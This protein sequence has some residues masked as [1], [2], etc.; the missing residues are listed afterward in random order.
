VGKDATA[1]GR[2][3][4]GRFVEGPSEAA[5]ALGRST[6][7]DVRLWRDD[8]AG[9]RAHLDEL[10]R[11]GLI[12]DDQRARIAKALDAIEAEFSAGEF[13]FADTDEDLHGAIE[14]RLIERAGEDGGRLRAGRSRNDQIATDLRRYLRRTIATELIP[15]VAALQ[16]A[17]VDQAEQAIDMVAPGYTHL[18]RAQPVTVAHH[19]LAHAWALERDGGRLED[20]ATRMDAS[21]LGAGAL[22][23]TTLPLDP[24]RYARALGFSSV[25][26]NSMDAVADR[27]FAVEFLSAAALLGVHLSRLG[28]EIVLWTSTEFAWASLGEAYSTGS[29]I[30]PQKR[31]PDV[32]ELVRGKT[33]RLVG[34]LVSLLVTLKGL[35]LTYNRD[36]QEDK[37][38]VFDAVDTLALTLPAIGGAVASLRFDAEGLAAKA[39]D[40][41]A[42]ATDLAEAL[43]GVG[44]PFRD[45]H[46]RVGRFVAECERTGRTLQDAA[47]ALPGAFPELAGRHDPGSLLAPDQ[48]VRRRSSAVG[49]APA[50]VRAQLRS[51]RAASIRRLDQ[52]SAVQTD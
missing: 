50:A 38:P 20:A 7:F 1:S 21:A 10:T 5:W 24:Q 46:E 43:V 23:G 17:L 4:G 39:G 3:W 30:M 32:A 52:S 19:L 35:P 42:M 12:N 34:D 18:Q 44:V 31:N 49:P 16:L 13:V 2:L 40:G 14:R 11:L 48:A 9:S 51:L 36:L 15:A 22:A 8:L 33:G 6:D 26:A 45:A 27:D 37:E 25:I 41:F 47:D 29:S 28:E